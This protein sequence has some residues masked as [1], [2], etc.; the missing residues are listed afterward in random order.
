MGKTKTKARRKAEP[1][2]RVFTLQVELYAGPVTEEFL[3]ENP[4]VRR[5]IE[6][7]GDQTLEDLHWAIFEAFDRDDEHLYEFQ[8]GGKRPQDPKAR[9]YVEEH[10][11]QN[12]WGAEPPAVADD[13]TL[14]SLELK[15]G[16]V[17]YYWFDFGDDWWHKIRVLRIQEEPIDRRKKFPRVIER[18]GAS[19]PQYPDWDDEYDE[20]DDY[21]E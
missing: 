20:E 9:Q 2:C 4:E 8:V 5:T 11:A 7:R 13:T 6:M 15:R 18:I 1:C 12:W 17:F 14:D 16:N 10:T 3:E 19:P 21:D